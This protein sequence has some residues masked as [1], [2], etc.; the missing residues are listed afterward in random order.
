M[1]IK[2][3][4]KRLLLALLAGILLALAVGWSGAVNIA[5]SSGHWKVTEWFLHWVMR[6]SVQTR[7]YW[8]SPKDV[9]DPSGLVSAAGH[10]ATACS[11]CHGAP[12]QRPSPVMQA[13]MPPA[14]DLSVNARQWTDRQLFWILEHGVKYSGMPAWPATGRED[15]I[16]RMV[17]FVRRLPGMSPAEYRRLTDGAFGAK[18]QGSFEACAGCHGS[19]GRGRGQPDI[20]VLGGQRA[21]YLLASLR[22]YQTGHRH[23]AVM[24][25]AVAPLP[26]EMLE[27][28]ARRFAAL[29]G[30]GGSHARADD[31]LA[32]Q[33]IHKGMP[34]REL[35][36]CVSC[37]TAGKRYPVLEG[38][39]ASFIAARLRRWRGDEDTVD[40][41]KSH[42]TMPV[43]ARRIPEDLID[44]IAH[45]YADAGRAD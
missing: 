4:I 22:A 13:A 38:Q 7:S 36:A 45:A 18:G 33:I 15:E 35:P 24:G 11:A 14:P 25:N 23:S 28:L 40:A 41:R 37:H 19:D 31:P 30:L 2:I 42:A 10:F 5:A 32:W 21:D 20:P 26:P 16:R 27:P 3:T 17:A 6:N 8:Q 34:E 43:I 44:R 12:G 39:K 9:A 1:T 29:P